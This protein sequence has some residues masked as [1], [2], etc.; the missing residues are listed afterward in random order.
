M[1]PS[2]RQAMDIR[3]SEYV[4]LLHHSPYAEHYTYVHKYHIVASY[5]LCILLRRYNTSQSKLPSVEQLSRSNSSIVIY[6]Y[7]T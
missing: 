1:K 7:I 2:F 5:I 4:S 6:P 3:T